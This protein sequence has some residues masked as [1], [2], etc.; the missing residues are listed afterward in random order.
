VKLQG[1]F[2]QAERKSPH[3]SYS[4]PYKED[5]SSLG[6]SGGKVNGFRGQL[7]FQVVH[8]FHKSSYGMITGKIT[9]EIFFKDGCFCNVDIKKVSK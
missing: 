2:M 5:Y 4:G 9:M 3:R 7:P 6:I 1:V 8:G